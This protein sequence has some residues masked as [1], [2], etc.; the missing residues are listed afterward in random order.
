MFK[1][2]KSSAHR[3]LT[4]KIWFTKSSKKNF[5]ITNLDRTS[6]KEYILISPLIK[7]TTLMIIEK[8]I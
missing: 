5:E 6:C 3:D 2:R 7:K 4:K 1:H 8:V